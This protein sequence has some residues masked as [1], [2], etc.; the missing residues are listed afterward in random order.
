ML[1]GA[2]DTLISN[3]DGRD[4]FSAGGLK[5]QMIEPMRRWR[6]IFNG[7]A[8]RISNGVVC[9]GHKHSEK[10]YFENISFQETEVHLRINL[11][12]A[13]FSRPFEF[14]REFS[15][16]LLAQGMA[17]ELWRGRQEWSRMR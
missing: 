5:F 11:I 10:Q 17:R 14:K 4:V 7:F 13:S 15:R 16:K 1:L 9:Q 2:P 12:W 6:I 3:T 8:K